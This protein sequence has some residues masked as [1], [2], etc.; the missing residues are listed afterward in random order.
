VGNSTLWISLT[1]PGFAVGQVLDVRPARKNS[2]H[3]LEDEL[4]LALAVS[5]ES[6]AGTSASEATCA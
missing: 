2:I 3:C 4:R 6:L 5:G 1:N